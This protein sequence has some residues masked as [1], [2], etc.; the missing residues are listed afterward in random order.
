[1]TELLPDRSPCEGDVDPEVVDVDQAGDILDVLSSETA[2]SVLLA[3]YQSAAPVSGLAETV[4]TSLQNVKYH[5]ERLERAGLVEVVDTRYSSKGNE[6]DVYA[7]G[8]APLVI[9]AGQ[10]EHEEAITEVVSDQAS[11]TTS[12]A[13]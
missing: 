7:P 12:R 10:R 3:L 8:R 4:D 6:M 2:R 9:F 5:I 13:Q 1:M 11:G